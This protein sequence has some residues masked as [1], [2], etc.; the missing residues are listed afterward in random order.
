M[1]G[2]VAG[3]TEASIEASS[4]ADAEGAQANPLLL[5]GGGDADSHL[6]TGLVVDIATK[7]SL[8]GRIV[9]I[10]NAQDQQDAGG[11]PTQRTTTDE[12]GR[13]ALDGVRTPYDAM[14][15]D[16]DRSTVTI[17]RGLSR[18]DPVLVHVPT[19]ISSDPSTGGLVNGNLSGGTTYP[20]SGRD[21]VT[22]EFFSPEAESHVYLGAGLPTGAGPSY[23]LGVQWAAPAA[24]TSG[25]LLAL[26]AFEVR[27]DAGGSAM[28][29]DAGST[30]WVASQLL[31]LGSAAV[32]DLTLSQVPDARVAGSAT[33]PSDYGLTE[34]IDYYQMPI[35]NSAF[36]VGDHLTSGNSFDNVVPD[37]TMLAASFCIEAQHTTADGEPR[38]FTDQCGVVLGSTSVM[39]TLQSPPSLLS[40][41]ASSTVGLGT[42]FTWN[43]FEGGVHRLELQAHDGA[44]GYPNIYVFT[45]DSRTEWPDLV[46]EGI[47]FPE[48][49]LYHA[50]IAGFAPFATMDDAFGPA[51][52]GSSVH[53]GLRQSFSA[54]TDVVTASP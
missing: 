19:A 21:Q 41:T 36:I 25:M 13:F 15:F 9:A 33:T 14:V 49:Q 4:P 24:T 28:P 37:L 35:A 22:V 29:A 45:M 42:P 27:P 7:R 16:R 20:L 46:S 31:T 18:L 8:A 53:T 2:T 23:Q 34:V 12:H 1:A 39:T 48:G 38:L 50:T 44:A 32:A 26:G 40:P 43:A 10:T 5:D 3:E 52:L 11:Q 51:G 54:E 47:S 30:S 17:Y 6:V